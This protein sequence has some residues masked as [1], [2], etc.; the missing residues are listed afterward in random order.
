VDQEDQI[1][2]V[3]CQAGAR[4]AN[5]SD[6]DLV[7]LRQAFDPVYAKLEQDPQTKAFIGQIETL[8]QSTTANP[9]LAIPAGCA[10]P[11]PIPSVVLQ[12]SDPLVGTWTTAKLTESQFVRAFVAMGG[13][14]KEGHEG[15]NAQQFLVVSLQFQGGVFVEYQSRDGGAAELANH[16]TYEIGN[17]GTFT[18]YTECIETYGYKVSGD[19]LRLHFVKVSCPQG[20]DVGPPFGPT[21]YA[22][23]PFTRSK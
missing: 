12:S 15:F 13:S 3:V 2:P 4:P 14:E 19:V 8:K 1:L 5:A 23:F 21:L 16:A 7:A 18:L 10:G 22:S 20:I 9:P 11:V 17:N 6:V